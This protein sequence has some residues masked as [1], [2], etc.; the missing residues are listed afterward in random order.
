MATNT[1]TD[2]TI[3]ALKAE[4]KPVKLFDGAGLFVLVKPTGAKYWRLKYR[5]GGVEKMLALGVYPEVSL[6]R[7]R[8]KRDEAR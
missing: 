5:H 2:A 4:A 6:K 7:A 8:E 3:K 1:L